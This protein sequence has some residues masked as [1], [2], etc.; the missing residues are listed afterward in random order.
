MNLIAAV[1]ENFGIGKDNQLPWHLPKEYAHF[2]RETTRTQEPNRINAVIMG[3][4]CWESIP[5]KFRPMRNR[6]N[7]I[8]SRTL[9]REIDV[10]F[11]DNLNLLFFKVSLSYLPILSLIKR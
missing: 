1:D 11:N 2:V 9:P 5:E 8:L 3:R 10:R 7:V 6:V 4:R